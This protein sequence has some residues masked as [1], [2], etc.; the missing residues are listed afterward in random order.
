MFVS[1]LKSSYKVG[2][3]YTIKDIFISEYAEG[4]F[5]IQC[6]ARRDILL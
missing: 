1:P 4:H 2:N 3:E 5:Q 6:R